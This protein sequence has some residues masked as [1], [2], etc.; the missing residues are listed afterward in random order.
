MEEEEE[1]W[2]E[3]ECVYNLIPYW[4]E[5]QRGAGVH[6]LLGNHLV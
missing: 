6:L 3:K 1:E 2:E 5:G 4:S